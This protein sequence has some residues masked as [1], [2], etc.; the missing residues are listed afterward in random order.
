MKMVNFKLGETNISMLRAWDKEKK[1]EFPTVFK[2]MTSQTPSGC[3]I[4][5]SY[6]ELMECHCEAMY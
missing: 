1:T 6:G 5:L 4:H 3:S 2:P